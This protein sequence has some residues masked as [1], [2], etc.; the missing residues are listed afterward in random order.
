MI[1]RILH[2]F[3]RIYT[4][5]WL[6]VA[7]VLLAVPEAGYLI[8]KFGTGL[9][10]DA[11]LP[12][13]FARD[14]VA[15]A[16]CITY[17]CVRVYAYHIGVE[18]YYEW[19]K[20]SPWTADQPLPFGTVFLLWQDVVFVGAIR[21]VLHD[22]NFS[23]LLIPNLFLF[24]YLF[25]TS[26]CLAGRES[27][28]SGFFLLLGLGLAA[29]LFVIEPI[30]ALG[31]LI[32]LSVFGTFAMRR[33]LRG[34]PWQADVEE[35]A[36][37]AKHLS[38]NSSRKKNQSDKKWHELASEPV[39][40]VWPYSALRLEAPGQLLRL[41]D[42]WRLSFLGGWFAYVL[43]S[44]LPIDEAPAVSLAP[45]GVGVSFAM[46]RICVYCS[47]HAPP[48]NTWGRIWTGRWI[49]PDY[50]KVFVAPLVTIFVGLL[51][52]IVAIIQPNQEATA[53]AIGVGIAFVCL[54][55]QLLGPRMS[56]WQLT[57]PCR[58][59]SGTKRTEL[60]EI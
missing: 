38:L 48:I 56:T 37:A 11:W 39:E 44:L 40:P 49:I 6:L 3:R 26:S 24:A 50:D 32:A 1:R 47:G 17:A 20:L 55:I 14:A 52:T 13:L 57:S 59:Y 15:V 58:L 46:I 33:S 60:I 21:L 19:L 2:W 45:F 34:F 29:K 22:Y 8:L 12:F 42:K 9:P 18:E 16:M 25:A 27:R 35:W 41:G 10:A 28:N 54:T 23:E 31:L 5:Q 4:L 51:G 30:A 36:R 7:V 53:V 43:A